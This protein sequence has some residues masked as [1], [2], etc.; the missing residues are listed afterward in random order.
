MFFSGDVDVDL[1]HVFDSPSRARGKDRPVTVTFGPDGRVEFTSHTRPIPRKKISALPCEV[2]GI[3]LY[4]QHS[5]NRHFKACKE[6]FDEDQRTMVIPTADTSLKEIRRFVD[7]HKLDVDTKIKTNRKKTD[8]VQDIRNLV[9]PE[10]QVSSFLA[11]PGTIT[12]DLCGCTVLKHGF[13]HHMQ[14]C[15]VRQEAVT[16]ETSL[17]LLN[18]TSS[19]A[20]S[21]F[22]SSKGLEIDKTKDKYAQLEEIQTHIQKHISKNVPNPCTSCPNCGKQVLKH[23]LRNHLEKCKVIL[24]G[25]KASGLLPQKI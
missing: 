17:P 9:H 22:I 21:A 7:V 13:N 16:N 15:K 11:S 10:D 14:K 4:D 5:Y 19:R 6:K 24:E 25:L 20:I 23:G 12:C 8:I 18:S 1:F 3:H 2:C